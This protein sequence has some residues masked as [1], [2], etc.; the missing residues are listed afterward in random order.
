MSF[1]PTAAGLSRR[2]LFSTAAAGGAA[3]AFAGAGA[4][5]ARRSDF[6]GFDPED[7]A[8]N[9]R[10]MA[11][12]AGD[13]NPLKT[14]HVRYVGRA[15]GAAPGEPVRPLYGLDGLG[16]TRIEMQEDGSARFLFS[17][18]AVYT[19]LET[20]EPLTEWTNPFTGRT[21]PVWHQRNGPVNFT[22]RPGMNA[23]GA[24]EATED[25]PGFRL[26]WRMENAMATFALDVVSTRPNPL[27]REDWPAESTGPQMHISEHSAYVVEPALLAD[28]SVTSL[29][30]NA[31]L[32]SLK[33]W[34]P[35][36]LMGE[37]PGLVFARLTASKVSGLD[38]IDPRAAA[39]A[40]AH[41]AEFIEA[42]AEWTGS[43]RT[44]HAIYADT[45]SPQPVAGEGGE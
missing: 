5:S 20:G 1:E 24:F 17:E 36:M 14:G 13:L 41:M 33:P 31:A 4:V 8:A 9:V 11:R 3:L 30:F 28:D 35:W 10:A 38:A 27:S 25:A 29:P 44:A 12:L 7:P 15:F 42:P 16:S 22:L 19:D 43:Y 6:A 45:Q 34:H 40:R 23:F 39:F 21:V 2:A 26:P 37:R 32:Q 18:F